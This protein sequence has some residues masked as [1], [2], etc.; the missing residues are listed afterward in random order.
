MSKE[1]I[2]KSIKEKLQIICDKIEKVLIEYNNNKSK[3]Y[4]YSRQTQDIYNIN[5][6]SKINVIK[7]LKQNVSLMQNNLETIYDI[8]KINKIESE[9][10]KK[11]LTIKNLSKE[12]KILC[13]LIQKQQE[14]IEDYSSKFTTNKEI[15]EFRNQLKFAK[16]ENHM[17][18][19]AFKLLNSKIKGQLS[20]IDILEK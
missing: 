13:D 5:N 20:K 1:N 10:K 4:D 19:E 18:R 11:N 9:I 7:S 12:Q 16:E 2:G 8:G 14:S 6:G 3:E 15:S 17:S